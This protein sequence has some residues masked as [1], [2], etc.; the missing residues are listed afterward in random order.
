MPTAHQT[1]ARVCSTLRTVV[2]Q[3]TPIRTRQRGSGLELQIG[4]DLVSLSPP[5]G[6]P[7]AGHLLH[8]LQ[9]LCR[10]GEGDGWRSWR[11]RRSGRD[12]TAETRASGALRS[13]PR[14]ERAT[15]SSTTETLTN[16]TCDDPPRPATDQTPR[17]Q[18]TTAYDEVDRTV[19]PLPGEA[20]ARGRRAAR[21]RVASRWFA[22][23]GLRAGGTL[24]AP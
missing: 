6:A 17:T 9:P 13:G 14:P 7:P 21:A 18:P 8:H 1:S 23:E 24:R 2:K 10:P 4:P 19:R 5:L 16:L 12:Q 3:H 15:A 20:T 22:A 11:R